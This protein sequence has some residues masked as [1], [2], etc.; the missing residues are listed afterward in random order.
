M[1]KTDNGAP[2]AATGLG[3]TRLSAWWIQLGIS[4]RR[5]PPGKPQHNGRHERMH[6]VL[7]Q[8][9]TRPHPAASLTGQQKRFD[10]FV[11]EYNLLRPHEG[12]DFATPA[13]LYTDSPRP[14][15]EKVTPPQYPEGSLVRR[16][17]NQ[18]SV[19]WQQ[20]YYYLS[21][22]LAGQDVW[23]VPHEEEPVLSVIYYRE[24]VGRVDL[25]TGRVLGPDPGA[26]P[27]TPEF[28]ALWPLQQAKEGGAT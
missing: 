11:C 8:E 15:P 20:H 5:I 6:R 28:A 14:Y 22:A 24:L 27:Q 7:K 18:G 10:A 9:T 16:V 25:A 12:V 13:S 23:L 1:I 3:L 21:A 19:R 4:P 26:L 2:F 17:K